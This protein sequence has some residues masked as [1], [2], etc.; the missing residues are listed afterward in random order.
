[1]AIDTGY[2]PALVIGSIVYIITAAVW[3]QLW[4]N[5]V[6]NRTPDRFKNDGCSLVLVGFLVVAGTVAWP[7][8]F[9]VLVLFVIPGM[10][11]V[12]FS[13]VVRATNTCCG[14]RKKTAE[15]IEMEP[16]R[17]KS[18][19]SEKWLRARSSQNWDA[20]STL[21][22]TIASNVMIATPQ[23]VQHC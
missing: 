13:K 19:E 11:L 8:T 3:S 7:I 10:F 9:A 22:P 15:D 12:K 16:R 20:E 4:Y 14:R 5:M 6:M 2:I 17:P 1:M 21:A 18:S 23:P